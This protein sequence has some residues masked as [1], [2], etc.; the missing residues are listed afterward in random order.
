MF[1]LSLMTQAERHALKLLLH[2]DFKAIT[3]ESLE[4]T[5]KTPK[6]FDGVPLPTEPTE[7]LRSINALIQATE[8]RLF[9]LRKARSSLKRMVT[10]AA[11]SARVLL[12]GGGGGPWWWC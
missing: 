8:E 9:G 11:A 3:L 10:N 6:K 12:G 4:E 2:E 5:T 7:C 1:E